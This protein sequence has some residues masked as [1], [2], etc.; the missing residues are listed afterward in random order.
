M[1]GPVRNHDSRRLSRREAL[2][3][4]IATCLVAAA[5]R[6]SG[7]A[8]SPGGIEPEVRK[9]IPSTGERLPVIGLGTNNYNVTSDEDLAPRREVLRRM[10]E[11]G[12]T[13]LDTAPAYGR[14]EIVVG[15]LLVELGN[16]ERF[17]LAT[18]VTAPDGDV[19]SGRAMLEDSFRRLR[20]PR[21]DL[22]QV[23]N[24]N[25][26][27]VLMPV[28]REAKESKRI[29]YIGVTTSN[30]EQYPQMIDVM[31]R[32]PLDFIQVDYSIDNRG[33][34]AQILPAAVERG[35]AV[36]VN[37]PFGGRRSGNLFARLTGRDVPRWAVAA[38]AA[39]WAQFLLRYVVSHPAVTCAIPGTHRLAHLEDNM[40]AGRGELPDAAMR[41]RMEEYWAT[42]G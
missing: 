39:S 13:V 11:L 23:H 4:G 37:M 35:F 31:R 2:R 28:L 17:F 40:R 27:D 7:A 25:G 26:V 5:P 29:R 32:H 24:L 8:D 14:S 41:T 12:G 15:D 10:P 20:S 30:A 36:L 9:A 34:A 33:A 6:A 21:I 1:G 19:A 22:V 16:R 38:G 42:V 3:A 18:K